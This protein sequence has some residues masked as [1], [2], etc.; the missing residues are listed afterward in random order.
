LGAPLNYGVMM[1]DTIL[2]QEVINWIKK[3]IAK[4]SSRADQYNLGYEDALKT[5]L[6]KLN[7]SYPQ[8][9]NK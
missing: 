8:K 7:I 1:N 4:D 9:G 2:S 6:V 3:E 5:I